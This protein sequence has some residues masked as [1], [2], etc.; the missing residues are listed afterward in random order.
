MHIVRSA[1]CQN[2]FRKA[3]I[4]CYLSMRPVRDWG[5]CK[6]ANVLNFASIIFVKVFKPMFTKNNLIT[7][8][9]WLQGCFC[10]K[11][12]RDEKNNGKKNA[13]EL[14]FFSLFKL[15]LFFG[16][17]SNDDVLSKE[18]KKLKMHQIKLINQNLK[19]SQFAACLIWYLISRKF[20]LY[21]TKILLSI[22]ITR[23][24]EWSFM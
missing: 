2:K 6:L 8:H 4:S 12:W 5:F 17:N 11:H 22:K 7:C 14:H 19:I 13:K 15:F 10:C 3:N 20:N 21:E 24:K 23:I 16:L 18:D 9:G 1:V